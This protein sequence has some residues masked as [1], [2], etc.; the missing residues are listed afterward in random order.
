MMPLIGAIAA[1]N[2]AVIKPSELAPNTALLIENMLSELFEKE[3][4]SVVNGGADAAAELTEAGFDFI[5]FTGSEKIGRKVYSAAASTITPVVLELGGK[6][7]CIV[8]NDADIPLSAKRIAWGK[9]L[10]SGQTCVAPDYLLIQNDILDEF[11]KQLIVEIKKQWSENPLL[12]PDYPKIISPAHLY[13]LISMLD[14]CKTIYGGKYDTLLNKLEPTILTDVSFDSRVM[15]EEI[16]G[17]ILPVIGFDDI[18]EI[19]DIISKRSSPLALYLFTN[20]KAAQRKITSSIQFG[21]CCINDT[22]SHLSSPNLPFGGIGSSGIGNYHGYYS[23]AAFS[24]FKSVLKKSTK[25][26]IELRYPPYS[27]KKLCAVKRALPFK[28]KN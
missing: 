7:P 25:I 6:S 10:N 1:G 16:F 15:S 13:R 2:T 3:F 24:H 8:L 27:K 20:D 4:I 12:N 9:F 26:D 17:P 5:F 18:S 28:I 23:F 22:V 21:G 11:I 19:F 14:D